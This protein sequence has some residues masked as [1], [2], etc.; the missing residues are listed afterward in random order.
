MTEF[1]DQL[2]AELQDL[3]V[4]I[5]SKLSIDDEPKPKSTSATSHNRRIGMSEV[6]D[7]QTLLDSAKRVFQLL[8]IEVR[9]L[10]PDQRLEFRKRA[11]EHEMSI[12]QLYRAFE[13]IREQLLLNGR[14]DS[15]QPS[16]INASK[17]I[18]S[19][20][21]VQEEDLK[22]LYRMQKMVE[23]TDQVGRT[24]LT[25]LKTQ[26]DELQDINKGL[27]H[28]ETG[29]GHADKLLRTMSRRITSLF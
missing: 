12:Q 16:N 5:R 15:T 7:I 19:A 28:V 10:S 25:K 29:L 11:K 14:S 13:N 3:E 6:A 9:D 27:G 26:T 2:E 1:A 4:N 8:K 22:S 23:S 20:K 17:L 18:E 21:M 24:T